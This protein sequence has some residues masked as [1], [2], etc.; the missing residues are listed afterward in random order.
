L[1][2]S[3]GREIDYNTR[4]DIEIEYVKIWGK[5]VKADLKLDHRP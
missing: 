2:S 1:T 5:I 4:E 3:D